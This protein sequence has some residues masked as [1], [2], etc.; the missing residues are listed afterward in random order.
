MASLAYGEPA[1][2]YPK[3]RALARSEWPPRPADL[4]VEPDDGPLPL[5]AL[6]AFWA[7]EFERAAELFAAQ[8]PSGIAD[9][10]AGVALFYLR[11][12]E[13][14]R[15]TLDRAVERCDGAARAE[16]HWQ[17]A[18]ARLVLGEIREARVDLEVVA[19]SDGART[20]PAREQLRAIDR[21]LDQAPEA[22]MRDW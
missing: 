1:G 2:V 13:Q 22:L 6:E 16:A 3:W 12:P 10:Y 19:W 14:A 11:R 7:R 8:E 18:Q 15:V 21:I 5:A 20:E 17:R 9:L 4:G